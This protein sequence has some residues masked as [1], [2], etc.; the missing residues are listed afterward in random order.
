MFVPDF[1]DLEMVLLF[2]MISSLHLALEEQQIAVAQV[3]QLTSNLAVCPP[4]M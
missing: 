1:L 4:G 2:D 3:L